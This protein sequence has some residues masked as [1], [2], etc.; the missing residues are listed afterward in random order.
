VVELFAAEV[1]AVL[2]RSPKRQ[3]D[4]DG[5]MREPETDVE[6]LTRAAKFAVDYSGLPL[7]QLLPIA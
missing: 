1:R 2:R 3:A 7:A 4:F 5:T 6:K